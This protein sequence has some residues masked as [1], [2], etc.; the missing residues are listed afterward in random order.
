MN[1]TATFRPTPFF[2]A[3]DPFP[4][5]PFGTSPAFR[6]SAGEAVTQ[7]LLKT[8]I[9]GFSAGFHSLSVGATPDLAASV[10]FE[11]DAPLGSAGIDASAIRIHSSC[12]SESGA[13]PASSAAD[14]SRP[15]AAS[16]GR[17]KTPAFL[18]FSDIRPTPAFP[19]YSDEALTDFLVETDLF[20]LSMGPG[21]IP[22]DDSL[23]F[24]ETREFDF[25]PLEGLSEF[26]ATLV[27]VDSLGLPRT[28][29][30]TASATLDWTG[31][32]DNSGRAV[33]TGASE[34]S[35]PRPSL[36]FPRSFAS[37]S[38]AFARSREFSQTRALFTPSLLLG[39]AQA[40]ASSLG[41]GAT[42]RP[43]GSRAFGE[44]ASLSLTE[45]LMLAEAKGDMISATSTTLVWVVVM[46][47]LALLVIG[48]LG[49][50]FILW[51]GQ[52]DSTIPAD[53]WKM[54][55]DLQPD[56]MPTKEELTALSDCE[57]TGQLE[58]EN[59]VM[60]SE[61]EYSGFGSFSDVD[62]GMGLTL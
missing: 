31:S 1:S 41:A 3:S 40:D 46:A 26:P 24:P 54:G 37:A 35:I 15:L 39:S 53:D 6:D 28:D 17:R 25:S 62:E 29:C 32:L 61:G 59:P 36:P 51:R 19:D 47:A 9:F 11:S 38:P 16:R 21:S 48:A 27:F 5:S 13:P 8:G 56:N 45:T 20:S 33:R 50:G 23:D 52:N 60:D 57:V 55:E 18:D 34:S 44:T 58:Y 14:G 49:C 12:P 10:N 22:Y 42:A 7:A 30:W 2:N 43:P 4:Q